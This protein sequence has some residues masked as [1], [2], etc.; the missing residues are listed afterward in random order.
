M[1]KQTLL[2]Y[3]PGYYKTSQVIDNLNNADAVELNR[4]DEK[5]DSALNQY[6]VDSAD[7]TLERWEKELGI[8][9]NNNYSPEFRRTRILSKIRGQGTITINLIK[10]VSQS[11][12]NGEVN[13]TEN[14]AQYSF[15]VKFIGTKGIPPNIDDLKNAIEDIKPA[16]LQAIFEFTYNPWSYVKT[17]TWGQ[18]KENTWA[19]LK[20][21]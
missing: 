15:T 8:E 14:N 12:S 1:D 7:F 4:L 2:S 3:M 18:V 20:E 16:H 19:S 9:V 21:R 5:L 17:M 10:T 6:F 11:F 13:I